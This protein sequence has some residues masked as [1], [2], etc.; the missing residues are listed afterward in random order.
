MSREDRPS[1]GPPLLSPEEWA[2]LK[3]ICKSKG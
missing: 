3:A 2:A 1:G